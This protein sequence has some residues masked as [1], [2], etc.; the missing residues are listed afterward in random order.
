MNL[1]R[2]KLRRTKK[3]ARF[4]GHH[5]HV[6]A[7]ANTKH[8]ETREQRLTISFETFDLHIHSTKARVW[9]K[10]ILFSV[11]TWTVLPTIWFS[12]HEHQFF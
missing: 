9:S 5:V 7:L 2:M 12:L 6:V 4:L 3:C 10:L 1:R 8:S 11:T